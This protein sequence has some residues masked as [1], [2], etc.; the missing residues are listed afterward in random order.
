MKG[1]FHS[2]DET[3][4]INSEDNDSNWEESSNEEDE[5]SDSNTKELPTANSCGIVFFLVFSPFS[6]I[7]N[8]F[9]QVVRKGFSRVSMIQRSKTKQ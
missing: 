7:F 1:I 6:P 8:C 2:D 9:F 3:I 4:M 5:S